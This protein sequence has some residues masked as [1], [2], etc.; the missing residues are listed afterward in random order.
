M[1][2]VVL[3]KVHLGI[4]QTWH[5]VWSE[6]ESHYC[7]CRERIEEGEKKIWKTEYV[8]RLGGVW[9]SGSCRRLSSDNPFLFMFFLPKAHG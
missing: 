9:L 4:S 5:G 6:G 7:G 1:K 2:V 3:E 8:V